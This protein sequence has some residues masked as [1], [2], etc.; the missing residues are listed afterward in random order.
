[1]NGMYRVLPPLAILLISVICLGCTTAG[2]PEA[3]PADRLERWLSREEPAEEPFLP[4]EPAKEPRQVSLTS[5][6]PAA[7][8]GP[9][10]EDLPKPE[11]VS[12]TLPEAGRVAITVSSDAGA[13]I[14]LLDRASGIIARSGSVGRED[15]RIDM[16]LDAG[17]YR[18]ESRTLREEDTADIRV[19]E[20]TALPVNEG[21][22]MNS[23]PGTLHKGSLKD[24]EQCSY[25][26]TVGENEPLV[27]EALGRCLQDVRVWKDGVW[28]LE[29]A[30]GVSGY[31]PTPG[32]TMGYAEVMLDVEP[33]N[34]LVTFYGGPRRDWEDET[35]AD[36]LY[37]RAGA[38]YLGST[39]DANTTIS[40]MGRDAFIVSGN[41]TVFEVEN[42]DFEP[43]TIGVSAGLSSGRFSS[44]TRASVQKDGES[45]RARVTT[46]PSEDRRWVYLEGTPGDTV[47]L[48]AI[49]SREYYLLEDVPAGSRYL[50]S[51]IS[52]LDADHA[53]DA[54]AMVVRERIKETD[55]EEVVRTTAVPVSPDRPLYRR[56]NTPEQVSMV[57]DLDTSG[58]WGFL[59]ENDDLPVAVAFVPLRELAGT[60]SPDFRT[61]N[62]ALFDQEAGSYLVLLGTE[63][64]GILS[65]VLYYSGERTASANERKARS[66]FET[67]APRPRQDVTFLTV[68]NEI[69]P[70]S[71]HAVI[72]NQ[73]GGP[74][75]ALF[76]EELPLDLREPVPVTVPAGE[77]LEIPVK[78][79]ARGMLSTGYAS[80]VLGTKGLSRAPEIPLETGYTVL[81]VTNRGENPAT[82][83]LRLD[84]GV[85][86]E[87]AVPEVPEISS[88]FPLLVPGYP[89][90]FDC[91]RDKVVR[92]LLRVDEPGFYELMTTG[93]LNTRI[94][95]RTRVNP[96]GEQAQSNGP[97][98]NALVQSYFRGG[99][100]LVEVSGVG[101][102]EGRAAL[103][104]ESLDLH[105]LGTMT[106]DTWYRTEL[107]PGT[108]L[109]GTVAITDPGRF[110]FNSFGLYGSSRVRVEDA[111][112]W[113]VLGDEL[114][115]G[116]YRMYSWPQDVMNRRL[117]GYFRKTLE[118]DLS[119]GEPWPLELNNPVRRVWME[120]AGRKHQEFI[121]NSPAD[122]P[123]QLRIE[124]GMEWRLRNP[125]G[126]L[127]A[128]GEGGSDLDLPAGTHRL[129]VRSREVSNRVSYT[130]SVSTEV[131]AEGLEQQ[132]ERL[133]A[134]VPVVV[135]KAGIY[136]FWSFGSRD[137]R[138]RLV[139]PDG[140]RILASGDD[141]EGDWNFFLSRY[142]PAGSYRLETEE[143]FSG[144]GRVT[145]LCRRSEEVR[146]ED[147]TL[148]LKA[149]IALADDIVGIPFTGGEEDALTVIRCDAGEVELS[150]YRGDRLLA[151]GTGMLAVPLA[152]EA[153]YLLRLRNGSLEP[154]DITL[155][156]TRSEAGL[157][158]F[159]GDVPLELPPGASVV[160][161]TGPS[162]VSGDPGVRLSGGLE[163]PALPAAGRVVSPSRGRLWCW[164][165]PAAAGG[166]L[167]P[168]VLTPGETLS[169]FPG[170]GG[171]QARLE[172]AEGMVYIV[173]AGTLDG[174]L[175]MDVFSTTGEPGVKRWFASDMENSSTILGVAPG[176]PSLVRLWDGE[177]APGRR[178]TL[179]TGA[180]PVVDVAVSAGAGPVTLEPGTAMVVD[181]GGEAFLS[182]LLSPGMVVFSG[183]QTRAARKDNRSVTIE[184]SGRV[185]LVNTGLRGGTARVEPG[186]EPET[187]TLAAAGLLELG[188]PDETPVDLCLDPAGLSADAE[189][190]LWAAGF[191]DA[192][193]LTDDGRR[194]TA[195]P[196][197]G[198]GNRYT[199]PAVPG[200]LRLSAVPGP[201]AVW[202]R[203]PGGGL[204]GWMLRGAGSGAE[205]LVPGENTLPEGPARRRFELAEG[206][207]V[208]LS[209]ES[210]G[211]TA[212]VNTDD[213]SLVRMAVGAGEE[214]EVYAL[215]GPGGYEVITR[216]L[217][218]E[219]QSSPLVFRSMVPEQISENLESPWLFLDAGETR[220]FGVEVAEEVPVGIGFEAENDLFEALL[221]DPSMKVIGKGR[222][223]YRTLSPG[224]YYVLVK[225]GEEPMRLKPVVA[226]NSGSRRGVPEQ[227]IKQYRG[228]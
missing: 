154:V 14:A 58:T 16:L 18:V 147:R 200:H 10:A 56:V 34:Y 186:R 225:N 214:R 157:L 162:V 134:T 100:Y 60:G 23:P 43:V 188:L 9:V 82:C 26:V 1:M 72:M 81:E 25:W 62:P 206:R 80:V 164:S 91:P 75:H 219:P 185:Y 85:S 47:R 204:P 222:Y 210:P 131:L 152:G 84:P 198:N 180:Y 189:V 177:P 51:S 155:E 41:A 175:G 108:G 223:F 212:L 126:D 11:Y 42:P 69:F 114:G 153:G 22:L 49:P 63:R 228:E 24:L 138:A 207:F 53:L 224:F 146:T 129:L 110:Y 33:G 15:G 117:S 140:S 89:V 67:E 139:T 217:A 163:T 116:V 182:V 48:R 196:V 71:E 97:G 37:V 77:T 195:R 92:F 118:P 113:P 213:D 79:H 74:V 59:H 96:R 20:F 208:L 226:G 156:I 218:G 88:L 221:L 4:E 203:E 170:D 78:P 94:T 121:L 55:R 61:E 87:Y 17:E 65:F 21:L 52:T 125:A 27:V 8:A 191:K 104:M 2:A 115:R 39:V 166:R 102:S 32:R 38:R 190:A 46:R 3:A 197:A 31:A 103:V 143:V 135:D 73:R 112:G 202:F 19:T 93:R 173:E 145:L 28:I 169:F 133:P 128:E 124:G 86:R 176:S 137:V 174:F 194:V 54:T 171:V 159:T 90:Y 209:T 187:H 107:P 123:V 105:G 99:L 64:P 136:D 7:P 184:S 101:P 165:D 68:K 36:P 167:K 12:F 13:E 40:P 205:V 76:V 149:R 120:N 220:V 211:V 109:T 215:L 66:L 122:I 151:R 161:A 199:L 119:E 158:E 57:V 201:L 83:V 160:S 29:Q 6:E 192:V 70:G 179:T 193:L 227:I 50:V 150:L 172:P 106:E 183:G 111:D 98:R 132:V 178:V 141:R 35:D 216:P 144:S 148:P 44:Y 30:G 5:L 45:T 130:L 95:T 142:L 168:L 127:L 181:A